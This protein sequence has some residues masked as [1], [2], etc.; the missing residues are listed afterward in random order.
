LLPEFL[1]ANQLALSGTVQLLGEKSMTFEIGSWVRWKDVCPIRLGYT[2]ADIG[3]VV[4]VPELPAQDDGIDV[5]FVNGEVLHGADG[6]WFEPVAGPENPDE[7]GGYETPA[8]Y[9]QWGTEPERLG[10]S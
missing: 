3:R 8:A 2:P 9:S 5:Q 6:D 10:R 1:L 7:M 4:R